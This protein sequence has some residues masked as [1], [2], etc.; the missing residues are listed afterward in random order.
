MQDHSL[1]RVS[2]PRH[3]P[4]QMSVLLYRYIEEKTRFHSD[5]LED[6]VIVLTLP[7]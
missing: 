3:N 6:R 5:I 1:S 7:A 4:S 2:Y